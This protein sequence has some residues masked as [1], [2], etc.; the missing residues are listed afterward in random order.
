MILAHQYLDQLS[1]NL[2]SAVLNTTGHLICFRVGYKDATSMAKEIFPSPDFMTTTTRSLR[3]RRPWGIPMLS[4]LRKEKPYGWDRL[5]QEIVRLPPRGFWH[6]RRGN[7]I[8]TQQRTF[9]MPD[10]IVSQ[11]AWEKRWAF[12]DTVGKQYGRLK[13]DLLEEIKAQ[14]SVPSR[15]RKETGSSFTHSFWSE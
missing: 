12:Q 8:P 7:Y 2:K 4:I 6:R 5:A 3:V 13:H 15:N 1:A 9:D 14:R 11:E 10:P